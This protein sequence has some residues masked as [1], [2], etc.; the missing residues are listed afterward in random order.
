[1]STLLYRIGKN[2]FHRPWYAIG[3]WLVVLAVIVTALF[4]G[5]IRVSSEIRIDGTPAQEVLDELATRIPEASGGQASVVFQAPVGDRIDSPENAAALAAVIDDIYRIDHVI[6]PR[7]LLA[8]Q[9]TAA[10]PPDTSAEPT[11]PSVSPSDP[12]ETVARVGPLVVAGQPVP[13]VMV[14]S[15]GRVA[16]LQVQFTDQVFELPT[17]TL[18]A[19]MTTAEQAANGTGI[20]VLSGATLGIPEILGVGESLGVGVAAI[21]LLITLGSLVA[22]G[23]PLL[24]AFTGVVI[25]VGGA[26]ALSNVIQL[27]SAAA[28]L[29]LMLG[30]AVGIDYALFI[31]NRQRRL[32]LDQGL[33]AH[34]ATGRAV[35]T[36]GS[37]VFFAGLTVII[38]LVALLVV[39]ITLLT[40]MALIAAAT[41]AIAVLVAL[42]LLPALMGLVGERVCT[43]GARTR[44]GRRMAHPHGSTLAERWAR[45]VVAHH[46]LAVGAAVVVLGVIA[47]PMTGMHLGL[48]S[49]QS[50]DADTAQRQSYDAVAGSLG[51]GYNGP[52]LV[53]ASSSHDGASISPDSVTRLTGALSGLDGVSAVVPSAASAN[54]DTVALTIIPDAGPTDPSTE[55]LVKAIRADSATYAQ[56]LGVDVGV[57]GI[58][59]MAIDVSQRLADVLPA[60]LALV[61]GLSLIVLL[62]VFRSILVPLK[63]TIG[64]LLS[65]LATFGATTAVFQW[66]W[67]QGF[68]GF[69]ATSP[70]LSF[71]PI[72]ATGV[73]YGLAMDYELF[74]VSSMRESYVHGHHGTETVVQGFRQASHVVAGAAIIMTSVF[75]GFVFNHDPMIKQIGFALAFGI[76]IDAFVVRMT[77]VPAVM[78][79]FGDK[80]WWL[81][82]W[83]DR[84]IPTLDVEGEQLITSLRATDQ[85]HAEAARS[86]TVR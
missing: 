15:T 31:V 86:T 76:L 37:A 16:M 67:L 38:A 41:V 84:L 6:D 18:E 43:Q 55:A 51:V 46:Y 8:A 58:T 70:V 80:A 54:G 5:T 9:A 61:V 82:R 59:A 10:S 85:Q 28:I 25:G 4:A 33:S 2:A 42:T 78:A 24:T 74:L 63:A 30:L 71:L 11:D 69:D 22:A 29:A 47:L 12:E 62:L 52:L 81:P 39:D 32:I 21:V 57:T 20:T 53:V 50:Y 13:G 17:G 36:A 19:V 44:H 3:A 14:S 56:D 83:L 75:A 23:L 64:F 40:M 49:G 48:P 77:L 1:M 73:L 27:N 35:G 7:A 65:V 79:M 34:E 72:I 26:Y 45:L 68:L 60:Y 66:G